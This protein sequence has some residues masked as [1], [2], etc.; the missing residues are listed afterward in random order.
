MAR[1]YQS[2]QFGLGYIPEHGDPCPAVRRSNPAGDLGGAVTRRARQHQ[3]PVA[4]HAFKSVHQPRDILPV[5]NRPDVQNDFLAG[6]H[7]SRRAFQPAFQAPSYAVM[8]HP[9]Q[10]RIDAQNLSDLARGEVRNR[11]NAIA[12]GGRIA[13]LCRKPRAKLGRRVFAGQYEQIVE[14]SNCA[15]QACVGQPLVQAVE[16]IRR[17]RRTRLAQQE[18]PGVWRQVFAPRG[19]KP[20]R[21]IAECETVMRMRARQAIQHLA[22]VYAHPG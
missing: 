17:S 20:V 21:A 1:A 11:D 18:T 22:R 9:H 13:R 15:A 19:Q 8:H 12:A 7:I 6:E 3:L 14:R 2:R 10:G 4:I 16:Q 5:L